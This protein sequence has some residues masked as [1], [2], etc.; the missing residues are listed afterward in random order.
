M[1]GDP[2]LGYE[3]P[4]T[5]PCEPAGDNG[6]FEHHDWEVVTLT[7]TPGWSL[8]QQAI[9]RKAL[10]Y[11]ADHKTWEPWETEFGTMTIAD[12]DPWYEAENA[13]DN[14]PELPE[15]EE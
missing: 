1:L 9:A 2:D 6:W 8:E 12:S 15:V 14:L 5:D 13:L 3:D 7:D 4:E 10:A 11:Y